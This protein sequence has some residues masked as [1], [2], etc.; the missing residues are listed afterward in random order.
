VQAF[1]A[2]GHTT[3]CIAWNEEQS[4]IIL[5]GATAQIVIWMSMLQTSLICCFCN[6]PYALE[7][8]KESWTLCLSLCRRSSVSCERGRVIRWKSNVVNEAQCTQIFT[9]HAQHSGSDVKISS[10]FYLPAQLRTHEALKHFI[11]ARLIRHC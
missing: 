11:F 7:R 4:G 3:L 8:T 10:S 9:T 1:A 2:D 6:T 5:H